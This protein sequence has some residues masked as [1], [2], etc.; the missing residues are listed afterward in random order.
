M[1]VDLIVFSILNKKDLKYSGIKAY[2]YE[3]TQLKNIREDWLYHRNIRY[4]YSNAYMNKILY[5][6]KLGLLFSAL[7]LSYLFIKIISSFISIFDSQK[8]IK[9]KLFKFRI[10]GIL[11][12]YF[13]RKI[14]RYY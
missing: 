11:K 10:K 12:Y 8:K 9:L 2:V 3:N 13:G 14:N 5:G 1:L 4:G 6:K 7:K